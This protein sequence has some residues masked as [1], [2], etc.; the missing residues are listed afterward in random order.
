[1]IIKIKNRIQ[2]C[3]KLI[4]YT[5]KYFIWE[6]IHITSW[7][8]LTWRHNYTK[9]SLQHPSFTFSIF[10]LELGKTHTKYFLSNRN[11]FLIPLP[12]VQQ[13]WLTG[14]IV[15][16]L[17]GSISEIFNKNQVALSLI[18]LIIYC[19]L[20]SQNLLSTEFS[21]LII[22]NRNPKVQKFLSILFVVLSASFLNIIEIFL[23]FRK[24]TI[25]NKTM[26]T[27]L[28]FKP[29]LDWIWKNTTLCIQKF[30]K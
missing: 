25:I 7:I 4:N 5:T 23:F 22:S 29:W 15:A 17:S 18:N 11:V 19:F 30:R 10:S 20:I 16:Y 27:I 21:S 2:I 28:Y 26:K 24:N 14:K 3:G 13:S 6:H 9:Q 12:L 1:M 8:R